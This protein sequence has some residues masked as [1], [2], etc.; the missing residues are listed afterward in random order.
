M[1]TPT[2][3]LPITLGVVTAADW[4]ARR[5]TDPH[6]WVTV[7][8]LMEHDRIDEAIACLDSHIEHTA[9]ARWLTNQGEKP[10]G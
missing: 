9:Y 5:D 1:T 7:D 6:L 10:N 4:L 2:G 3:N 8:F